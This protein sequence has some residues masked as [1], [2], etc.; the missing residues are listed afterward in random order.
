MG[1]TPECRLTSLDPEHPTQ[2][3]VFG[4]EHELD[5][6]ACGGR[7][8]GNVTRRIRRTVLHHPQLGS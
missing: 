5:V 6:L 7:L 1:R 2:Y 4:R 8:V 3:H